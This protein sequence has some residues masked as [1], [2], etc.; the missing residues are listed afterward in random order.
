MKAIHITLLGLFSLCMSCKKDLIEKN[1][2]SATVNL[3]NAVASYDVE[4]TMNFTGGS[5]I[6]AEAKNLGYF[7]YN[8]KYSNGA[9][10]YA[11][12]SDI[13]FPLIV[14]PVN[15][16]TKPF[17]SQSV[18]IGKGESYTLFTTGYA[19]APT[20]FLVKDNL[21]SRS[22]STGIRVVNLSPN[23]DKF[24]VNIFWGD[25]SRQFTNLAYKDISSF[26]SLPANIA[27]PFYM[28]E[29]RDALTDELL[30]EYFL[31]EVSRQKNITLIVRGLVYGDPFLEVVRMNH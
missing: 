19:E 11:I 6:Y 12:P 14:T 7:N 3:V 27:E 8:G 17:F 31:D 15:D 20:A 9:L 28:V 30:C 10:A 1:L 18:S 26:T 13:E 22:D 5:F 24:N 29:V 21:I 16:T 23:S 2:Y 4:I 25:Y